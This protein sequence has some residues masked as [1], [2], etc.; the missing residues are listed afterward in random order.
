MLSL[1]NFIFLMYIY[2]FQIDIFGVCLIDYKV[3][4][5]DFDVFYIERNL[6]FCEML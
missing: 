3:L 2:V 5:F 1:L 6:R 4:E